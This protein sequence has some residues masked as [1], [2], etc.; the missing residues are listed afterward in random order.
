MFR[1]SEC[2]VIGFDLDMTL[3]R[4]KTSA[5]LQLCFDSLASFLVEQKNYPNSILTPFNQA[6]RQ[7]LSK[8]LIVDLIAFNVKFINGEGKIAAQLES[9]RFGCFGYFG[10]LLK[11]KL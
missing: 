2:D 8:H 9:I 7:M 11:L 5:M 1:L 3:C 10:N 6:E 4:Y